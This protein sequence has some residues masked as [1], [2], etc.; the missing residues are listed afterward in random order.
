MTTVYRVST[1]EA[2]AEYSCEPERAV[3]CAWSQLRL[4]LPRGDFNTW[5]YD[6]S[7]ARP[8]QHGWVCGYGDEI[9]WA[10]RQ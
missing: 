10:R 4:A 2:V 7:L 8:T 9:Y 3:V 6:W 5:Q 1:G